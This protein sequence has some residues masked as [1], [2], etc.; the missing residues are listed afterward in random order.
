MECIPISV[1]ADV[2]HSFRNHRLFYLEW[3]E[4][5]SLS[6]FGQNKIVLAHEVWIFLG[7]LDEFETGTTE[8][9]APCDISDILRDVD[10]T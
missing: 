10:V 2:F 4:Y 3:A 8:S 6:I 1:R 5:H 9:G 7:D